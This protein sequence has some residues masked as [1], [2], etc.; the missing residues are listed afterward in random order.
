MCA[1]ESRTIVGGGGYSAIAPP[2]LSLQNNEALFN[3]ATT[4]IN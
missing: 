1:V 4:L 3:L 2:T